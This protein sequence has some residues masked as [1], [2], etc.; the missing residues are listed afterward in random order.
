M[1]DTKPKFI[2]EVDSEGIGKHSQNGNIT[3]IN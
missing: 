2:G 1:E 3:R